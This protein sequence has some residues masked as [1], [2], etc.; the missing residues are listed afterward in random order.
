MVI[1]NTPEQFIACDIC[2]ECTELSRRT[3]ADPEKVMILYE[4]MVEDHRDCEQYKHDPR[5]AK[6]H[7][8]YKARMREEMDKASGGGRTRRRA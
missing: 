5:T 8:G 6:L 1:R 3:L 4:Q 2:E 7:R